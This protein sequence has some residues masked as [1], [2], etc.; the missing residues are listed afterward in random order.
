MMNRFRNRIVMY[1]IAA[2]VLASAIA[3]VAAAVM[4]PGIVTR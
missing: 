4:P 1:T 2:L 3:G